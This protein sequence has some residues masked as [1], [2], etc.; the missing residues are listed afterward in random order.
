[1]STVTD[2]RERTGPQT[3]D[4]HTYSYD[5]AG[6][7]TRIRDDR[8]DATSVDDQCFRY[9]YQRRLTDAWTATDS[10]SASPSAA[11]VGGVAPYWQTFSYDAAGN[12][13]TE[14]RHSTTGT[15]SGDVT[16]TYSY[17]AAGQAQPHTLTSVVSTG[18]ASRT[19]SYGY[20]P[21]G[22]TTSRVTAAGNQSLTWDA[23]GKLATSTIA[24]A[25]TSFLYDPD[26]DR[27]LRRDPKS[28]TLYVGDDEITLDRT[29]GSLSGVRYYE[30]PDAT[31]VRSSTGTISYLLADQHGTNELEVDASTLAYTP[32]D[33]TPFG[34]SRGTVPASWPDD[35]GFVG[36]TADATTGGLTEV[37]ARDYDPDIGRFI[38]VDP[39]LDATDPQQIN[40]YTYSNSN[41]VTFSDPDGKRL[42]TNDLEGYCYYHGNCKSK[43]E[44]A[45]YVKRKKQE[46]TSWRKYYSWC[47]SH[48]RACE[49]LGKKTVHKKK[50]A[51]K[52]KAK[53][54]G[55]CHGFW[56]CAWHATKKVG[57]W[58]NKNRTTLLSICALVATVVCGV[59]AMISGSIDAYHDFHDGHYLSGALDIVGVA[60]GAGSLRYARLAKLNELKAGRLLL[61][62][63]PR[64]IIPKTRAVWRS[65][66]VAGYLRKANNYNY[67]SG[68][69]S[70]FGIFT[71]GNYA[72]A[73]ISRDMTG[74]G[75]E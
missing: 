64:W 65:N 40:G 69:W 1:L 74:W 5:A 27:L 25:S 63:P 31:V 21:T 35:K 57:H 58:V 19:D 44:H 52:K 39:V 10:C 68:N 70:N 43:K 26:G 3:M 28:T 37:G 41:P 20:D 38:S 12:R 59:G 60:A 4:K 73:G 36:G 47:S 8:N 56:G 75:W 14:V 2:D 72:A 9:D 61:K 15:T 11:T 51:P 48:K 46:D 71:T 53:K 55:G 16:R 13:R 66:K 62:R 49:N 45:Y 30:V 24:G 23:E 22:D 33:T 42:N 6:N 54:K 7:V 18:A 34:G 50:A 67:R 17:P 29:S 32:R